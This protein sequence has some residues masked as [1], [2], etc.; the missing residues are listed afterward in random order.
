MN[1]TELTDKRI[2]VLLSG[3]VDSSVVVSVLARQGLHPDCYY[4]KIGPEDTG[5]DTWDCTA[6][7]DLEEGE[8][9]E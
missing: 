1:A 5:S 2:C 3:G 6:E 4:I 9:N 7:E 8:P